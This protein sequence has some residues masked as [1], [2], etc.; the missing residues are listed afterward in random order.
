M[1]TVRVSPR[2][3]IGAWLRALSSLL[4]LAGILAW[5]QPASLLATVETVSVAWLGVAL[6]LGVAQ[7]LLSAWRWR[8]TARLLGMAL[9]LR[10]AVSEYYRGSFLNQVVPGGVVGDATRAWR[11]ARAQ[12]S[13][14]EAWHAVVIERA[15][16]QLVLLACA[17]LALPFAPALREVLLAWLARSGASAAAIAAAA[18]L[19]AVLAARRAGSAPRRFLRDL[20]RALLARTAWPRQLLVSLALVCSYIAV[21]LCCARAIGVQSSALVL[22]PLVCWVL[23]AM[24]L[25]FSLAGWGIREGAAA[26][27]WLLA[28]L[29]AA[30]GVA[31]SLLYG[32]IV[33]V[34]ALPGAWFLLAGNPAR[35]TTAAR[36]SEPVNLSTAVAR[37]SICERDKARCAK[38]REFGGPND[39]RFR[40]A[41]RR[42]S[43]KAAVAA[44]GR[45]IHRL[46]DAPA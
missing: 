34:S 9:P 45:K 2:R 19:L 24:A 22:A 32:S 13:G 1:S 23:L 35:S 12:V 11:H 21:Y 4:L 14:R 25:P 10:S 28:G 26:A 6:L 38:T 15:S 31:V 29:P 43:R 41:Q 40:A 27:L 46:S 3:R 44:G 8:L 5:I 42:R 39:R 36:A 30:Q 18:A 33:L 37:P 17:L 7:V 16:G 20:S